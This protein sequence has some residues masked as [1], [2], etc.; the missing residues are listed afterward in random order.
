MA[1]RAR[2]S[3]AR[4]SSPPRSGYRARSRAPSR[5]AARG[6]TRSRN[7]TQTVKIVLQTASAPRLGDASVGTIR[8]GRA[9]F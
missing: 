8:A 7:G 1:Y 4:R 5:R 9:K 2:R 3:T 6:R